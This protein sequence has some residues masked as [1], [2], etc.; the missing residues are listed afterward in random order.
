M[1]PKMLTVSALV[2][3]AVYI[4]GRRAKRLMGAELA[5]VCALAQEDEEDEDENEDEDDE[6]TDHVV[7]KPDWTIHGRTL[8]RWAI[9]DRGS[10]E[11]IG[12]PFSFQAGEQADAIVRNYFQQHDLDVV[13]DND[14]MCAFVAYS[15]AEVLGLIAINNFYYLE[16]QGI[17]DATNP[18]HLAIREGIRSSLVGGSQRICWYALY[19]ATNT[20]VEEPYGPSID[21]DELPPLE[22]VTEVGE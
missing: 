9:T 3:G 8:N 2:A 1:I 10:K 15:V 6:E 4:L 21:P 18:E 19:K 20:V 7:F 12:I 17:L 13:L 5:S 22:N 16:T 11:G 14:E